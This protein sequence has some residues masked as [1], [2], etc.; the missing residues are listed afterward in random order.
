MLGPRQFLLFIFI[1]FGLY[2]NSVVIW[3]HLSDLV[4]WMLFL[5]S[6]WNLENKLK[7]QGE[8]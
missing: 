1:Y 3:A 6:L 8:H 2:N 4:R 7:H 5:A